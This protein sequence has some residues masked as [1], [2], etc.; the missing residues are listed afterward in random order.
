MSTQKK[1][2]VEV[3]TTFFCCLQSPLKQEYM[4]FKS[5]GFLIF[6]RFP[7]KNEKTSTL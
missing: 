1:V 2:Y 3:E 5:G 6:E 4:G 7:A